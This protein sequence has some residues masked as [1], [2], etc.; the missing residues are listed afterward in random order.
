M[1]KK[2]LFITIACVFLNLFYAQTICDPN[3]GMAGIYP[4]N[5]YDFLSRTPISILATTAGNPEGRDIFFWG[6]T[7]P[8]DGKE[9]AIVAMSNS[10]AFVDVSD[11]INPIFLGRIETAAGNKF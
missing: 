8:L 1:T 7:D 4:C 5:N 11:P 3:T 9:Y 2:Y 6:G 10:T